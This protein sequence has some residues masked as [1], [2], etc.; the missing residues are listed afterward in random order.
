MLGIIMCSEFIYTLFEIVIMWFGFY[1]ITY[2]GANPTETFISCTGIFISL[3]IISKTR[4]M[5][6]RN[7]CKQYNR[8]A[9]SL[10]RIIFE[11]NH[12][13]AETERL[14]KSIDNHYNFGTNLTWKKINQKN[15][16]AIEGVYMAVCIA[17]E[18]E[19]TIG[20]VIFK[21]NK[22]ELKNYDGH[23]G[24]LKIIAYAEETRKEIVINDKSN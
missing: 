20:P 9:P 2:K 16:N 18:K 11:T 3:F 5:L 23:L 17:H 24:K 19:I 1:L 8:F 12:S 22:W 13:R 15:T 21:D 7:E 14:C 10:K 6:P 4:K